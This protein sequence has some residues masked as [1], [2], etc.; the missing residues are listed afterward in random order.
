MAATASASSAAL[1]LQVGSHS[2][3]Q[4]NTF[5]A[6]NNIKM[7]AKFIALVFLAILFN[8]YVAFLMK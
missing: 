1:L 7:N 2:P 4:T 3:L 5:D 8:L 6:H